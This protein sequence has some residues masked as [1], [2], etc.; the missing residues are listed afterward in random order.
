MILIVLEQTIISLTQITIIFI[1]PLFQFLFAFDPSTP[2]LI[3]HIR[4]MITAT[5]ASCMIEE[6]DPFRKKILK[7]PRRCTFT[8]IINT[9]ITYLRLELTKMIMIDVNKGRV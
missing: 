4:I 8:A 5:P 3:F 6:F 7:E 2:I 9:V 1:R